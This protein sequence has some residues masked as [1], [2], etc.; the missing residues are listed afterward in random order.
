MNIPST[1]VRSNRM[2]PH[3]YR[4]YSTSPSSKHSVSFITPIIIILV[5]HPTLSYCPI[6]SHPIINPPI[7]GLLAKP[8]TTQLLPPLQL[9]P[10]AAL[11]PELPE[12][13]IQS[14]RSKHD[15][16]VDVNLN[17][18]ASFGRKDAKEVGEEK[19]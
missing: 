16:F 11:L 4:Q 5:P 1:S 3:I 2:T 13:E 19:D 14:H 6:S 9:L 15:P 10:R 7:N 8:A 12:R 17:I 18:N